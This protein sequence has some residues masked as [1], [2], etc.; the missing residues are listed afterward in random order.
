M[1]TAPLPVGVVQMDGREVRL[2]LAMD[3]G[4][5]VLDL[6]EFA[7]FAGVLM[8]SKNGLTLPVDHLDALSDLIAEAIAR[9]KVAGW[10]TEDAQP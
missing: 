4:R 2:A 3:R 9:A 1:T 5:R 6:R 8:P 10:L 7:P